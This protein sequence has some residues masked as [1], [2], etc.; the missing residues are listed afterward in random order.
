[1]WHTYD[2]NGRTQKLD[3]VTVTAIRKSKVVDNSFQ[4]A[5]NQTLAV[6]N[7]S[8]AEESNWKISQGEFSKGNYSAI[9]ASQLT[10]YK[11]WAQAEKDY[12]TMSYAAVAVIGAPL[13]IAGA[14]GLFGV[15]TELAG[16]KATLSFGFQAMFNGVRNVDYVGVA[17]DA[18]TAPGMDALI[19][20]SINWRPFA[21]PGQK[22]RIIGINK[23]STDFLFDAGATFLGGMAGD[24]AWR[25]LQP[26]LHNPTEK[27]AFYLSTQMWLSAGTI[28]ANKIISETDA[29]KK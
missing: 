4:K 12:R 10:M 22:L 19:N 11:N 8:A 21:D 6:F 26:L 20:G 27:T 28:G 29:N 3:A 13:T 16:A 25:P 18:W 2:K 9:S 14:P 23:G 17:A 7:H 15:S 24:A 5:F 1:M